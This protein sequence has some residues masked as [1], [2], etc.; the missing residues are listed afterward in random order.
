MAKTRLEK[1]EEVK[2]LADNFNSA[3]AVVFTSY[4][5]L[6]VA[7]S[8]ELRRKLRQAEVSYLA[9]KKTLLKMVLKEKKLDINVDELTGS[10]ALAFSKEDEVS[11]AKV[12][13]DFAKSQESLK[14]QG[15]ILEG[16]FISASKIL[17]LAKLP[18]KLEMLAQT[19]RIIQAPISGLVNVLA[20][21]LRGLLNVLNSIK[22]IKD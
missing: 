8:Q 9:C 1:Q 16:K 19:V 7:K 21:N 11:P 10:L 2:K 12:L 6:T 20:G 5:K 22:Q 18:S 14:I 4:D 13:A 3:V 17:E 15:G